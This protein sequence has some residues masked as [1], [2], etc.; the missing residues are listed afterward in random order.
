M[1]S[2]PT[3]EKISPSGLDCWRLCDALSVSQA[4]ALVAGCDP[5]SEKGS[6]DGLQPYEKSPG[7]EAAK[8]AISNALSKGSIG[9]RH[10]CLFER[11]LDGRILNPIIGS[12][13]VDKSTVT[14]ESLREWLSSRG[15]RTGFFFPAE[16][17]VPE[18]LDPQH[19][20]YARKLAAAV[21][22]WQAVTDPNGKHPKQALTTWLRGNAKKFCMTDKKGKPIESAI[23]E[24]AKVANWQSGGGAPKTPGG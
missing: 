22:A 2:K 5:S 15:I 23:E 10:E 13:D 8:N 11:D 17:I 6:A 24:V 3:A 20:R 19:P 18:Y 7:Y 1:A 4:A 9:G 14:V 16:T 21:S 12:V